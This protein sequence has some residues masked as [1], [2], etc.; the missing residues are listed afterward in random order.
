MSAAESAAR[1]RRFA[2]QEARG[3]SPTYERLALAVAEDPATLRFLGQLDPPRRQPNLLFAAL[4]WHG[5]DVANPWEALSWLHA[6]PGDVLSVMRA[7]RTQT[8]EAARCA[9]LLPALAQL[10]PPLAL[11]E[12]GASAGLCLLYDAWR[13]RYTGPGIDHEVGPTDCPVVLHCTVAGDVP[14]PNEVPTIA[15]RAG[16]D[17][18]PIDPGDPESRRWLECLVWPEHHDRAATLRA[19]LD[20]ATEVVPVVHQGDLLN[21]LPALLE[22]A[23]RSVTTVVAH[24]ATLGYVD[25]HTRTAFLALVAHHGAHRL[26]LEAPGVLPLP[27][28]AHVRTEGRLI[29][30]LDDQA[31]GIAHPHGR[32][33]A[34]LQRTEVRL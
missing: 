24:S 27:V 26:G 22:R 18:N 16:L 29:V 1:Y 2:Q 20:V 9:V 10:P 32:S 14:L 34:W 21:G 4:R 23:P 17:L 5:V 12:V 3:S 11:I 7:R 33:L 30:S 19:A 25:Q 13:Y 28:P 8:N 6:H 31:L 15:W